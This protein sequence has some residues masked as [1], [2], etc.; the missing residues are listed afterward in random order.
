MSE[1]ERGASVVAAIV[2]MAHNLDIRVVAEGIEEH[3]Q[4]ASLAD[5]SCDFGQ[6]YFMSRP[7]PV[8]DV[9]PLLGKPLPLAG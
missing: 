3:A 9:V 2:T 8:E 5:M 4:L 1:S 6:G 7:L